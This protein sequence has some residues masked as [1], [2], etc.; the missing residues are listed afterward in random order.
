MRNKNA[1]P[2]FP[3]DSE[4]SSSFFPP[5]HHHVGPLKGDEYV[6]LPL[7]VE[8]EKSARLPMPSL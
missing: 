5:R 6:F 3:L 2:F 7:N 4:D 8:Q 1:P